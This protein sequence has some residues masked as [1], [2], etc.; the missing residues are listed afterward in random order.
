MEETLDG[1]YKIGQEYEEIGVLV[2]F[3]MCFGEHKCLDETCIT[4]CG[5]VLLFGSLKNRPIC[6]YNEYDEPE[7]EK[8]I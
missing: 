5:G 8:I 6:G 4:K 1:H 7:F 3:H 2:D